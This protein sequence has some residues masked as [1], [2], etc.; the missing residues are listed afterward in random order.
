MEKCKQTLIDSLS[1]RYV[2]VFNDYSCLNDWFEIDTLEGE[3]EARSALRSAGLDSAKVFT[4]DKS[5][6]D[7]ES[8]Q[9]VLQMPVAWD[10]LTE[11]DVLETCATKTSLLFTL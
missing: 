6:V 1:S 5:V 8:I 11:E 4:L 10:R 2:A 7:L 9:E 3:A